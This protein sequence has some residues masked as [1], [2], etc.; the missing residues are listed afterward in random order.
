[1]AGYFRRSLIEL[2]RHNV[3]NEYYMYMYIIVVFLRGIISCILLS[4]LSVNTGPS[5]YDR[6]SILTGP[7]LYDRRS[8]LT[9]PSL[10]D[11]R[12][13]LTGPTLYDR[14]S[15]LTGPTLYD[16]SPFSLD[17]PCMIVGQ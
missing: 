7:S 15:I 8:I 9:G 10:Y 3:Q 4:S 13:I 12:S 6:R 5:L 1:M 11:R 2:N 17:L 16:R 14:R